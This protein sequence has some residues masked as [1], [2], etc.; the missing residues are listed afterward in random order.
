MT[1]FESPTFPYVKVKI[2][3]SQHPV[4]LNVATPRG[5]GWLYLD[6]KS[7]PFQV[8]NTKDR[9][10]SKKLSFPQTCDVMQFFLDLMQHDNST[11]YDHR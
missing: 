2:S 7:S 1:L 8:T 4:T 10:P 6:D 3:R 11:L 5:F 9:S